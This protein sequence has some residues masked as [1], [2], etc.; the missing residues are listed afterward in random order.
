MKKLIIWALSLISLSAVAD[1]AEDREDVPEV[2][3]GHYLVATNYEYVAIQT[4]GIST[5][6]AVTIYDRTLKVGALLHVSSGVHI[7][8]ALDNIFLELQGQG[9]QIS[10]LEVRLNGGWSQS[11]D[12]F[13]MGMVYDSD[14][15]VRELLEYFIKHKIEVVEN[16]T[17]T[18]LSDLD[19][20]RPAI[21][22]VEL[23]LEDGRVYFYNQTVFF[24][25][26][27][28]S[29]P[30]PQSSSRLRVQ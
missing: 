5:C 26:G 29:Y 25:K 18:E 3:I 1:L 27:S 17:L 6:I 22:N 14:R 19:N 8:R 21:I 4:Y 13:S 11:M 7:R 15:M 9:V 28:V 30:M 2:D 10:N 16:S 20:G 12:Q 23:N 24:K